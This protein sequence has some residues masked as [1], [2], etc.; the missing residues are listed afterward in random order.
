MPTP[1][2]PYSSSSPHPFEEDILAPIPEG[3]SAAEA[4]AGEAIVPSAMTAE[5]KAAIDAASQAEVPPMR[6]A[7][8]VA[9]EPVPAT[10]PVGPA[11]AGAPAAPMAAEAANAQET[12]VLGAVNP[13]PGAHA[14]Q[15]GPAAQETAVLSPVAQ[16][17]KVVG[18]LSLDEPA[19]SVEN[20]DIPNA[21]DAA[22]P[23]QQP[24]PQAHRPT[25]ARPEATLA[26]GS[27][28]AAEPS[29]PSGAEP[30]VEAPV[31]RSV[32][33]TAADSLA[34]APGTMPQSATSASDVDNP[35]QPAEPADSTWDAAPAAVGAIPDAPKSRVGAHIG[36]FFA[37]LLLVPLAWYLLSDSSIRLSMIEGNQWETGKVAIPVLLETIGG[38]VLTGLVWFLA[39]ASS[40]GAFVWGLALTA[41]GA[42][43]VIMPYFARNT[44]AAWVTDKIGEINTLTGNIAHHFALDLGAGRILF[45]GFILLMTSVVSHYARKRGHLAGIQITRREVALGK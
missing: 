45:F 24:A 23:A 12:A 30:V 28:Y 26:D 42:I 31:R 17:P 13:A 44:I 34:P 39:R 32:M 8:E 14:A 3:T 2:D 16:G 18:S 7:A 38:L 20:A 36:I 35:F 40:L 11:G 25:V 9:A 37:T 21:F 4:A 22:E 43:G 6:T 10:A 15:A 27:G 1:T 29:V 41:L 5:Q 33:D 19:V